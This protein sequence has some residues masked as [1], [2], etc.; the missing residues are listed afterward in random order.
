VTFYDTANNNLGNHQFGSDDGGGVSVGPFPLNGDSVWRMDLPQ[1][2]PATKIVLRVG[3]GG[4]ARFHAYGTSM[5][6]MT[7][8]DDL[9]RDGGG[10]T[11]AVVVDVSDA[12]YGDPQLVLRPSREGKS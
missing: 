4:L 11:T 6:S 10:K 7:E 8:E 12:S 9:L 3:E 1:P 5:E 2:I